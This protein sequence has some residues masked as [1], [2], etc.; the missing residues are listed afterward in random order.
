MV[1]INTAED[2][3]TSLRSDPELLRQVRLAIM[4]Y[5]VLALPKQVQ[6]IL[7]TQ[8]ETLA[9][10]A[11]DIFWYPVEEEEMEPEDTTYLKPSRADRATPIHSA[12]H[13]NQTNHS[14]DRR[15]QE[16]YSSPFRL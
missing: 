3:L 13:P 15:H 7:Q 4:T 5:D 1:T 14:S 12:H 9:D 8:S 16:K 11:S 2:I 6:S 10:I